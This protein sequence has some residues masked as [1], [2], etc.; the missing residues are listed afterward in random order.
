MEGG[1]EHGQA[2][3][4]MCA[5]SD[6]TLEELCC[7]MGPG[8]WM[9]APADSHLKEVTCRMRPGPQIGAPVDSHLKEASR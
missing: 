1:W 4:Q 7:Q 5:P 3:C 9:G 2:H 6:C 8:A